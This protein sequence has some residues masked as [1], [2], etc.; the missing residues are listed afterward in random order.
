MVGAAHQARQTDR[1]L[2]LLGQQRLRAGKTHLIHLSGINTAEF[3]TKKSEQKLV[4]RS[5]AYATNAAN[6]K[7]G[8]LRQPQRRPRVAARAPLA[9]AVR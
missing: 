5:V 9:R 8:R 4:D 6:A 1:L 3:M 7:A 2:P